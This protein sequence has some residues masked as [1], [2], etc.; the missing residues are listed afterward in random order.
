[1]NLRPILNPDHAPKGDMLDAL[2]W[3]ETRCRIRGTA[4]VTEDDV[5]KFL[6]DE[7]RPDL[8]VAFVTDFLL[9]LPDAAQ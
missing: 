4:F 2:T 3:L 8:A 7:G 6:R 1:M 9:P 5:L